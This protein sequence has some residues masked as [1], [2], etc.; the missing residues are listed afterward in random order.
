MRLSIFCSSICQWMLN[1]GKTWELFKKR[2]SKNSGIFLVV[3]VVVVVAAEKV[4]MEGSSSS[5]TRYSE[6]GSEW[7][8]RM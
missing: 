2:K 5:G 7:H 4:E 6:E 8:L 1:I 3:V